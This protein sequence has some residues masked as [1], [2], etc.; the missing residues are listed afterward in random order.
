MEGFAF[1]GFSY[2]ETLAKIGK[3][4]RVGDMV[5]NFETLKVTKAGKVINLTESDLKYLAVLISFGGKVA[6][7]GTLYRIV[8]GMDGG[9]T[10]SVDTFISRLRHH[11]GRHI[12]TVHC[13]GYRW[14]VSPVDGKPDFRFRN[15]NNPRKVESRK[16]SVI[17]NRH[18]ERKEKLEKRTQV[19]TKSLSP[20]PVK[21]STP[22]VVTTM[23]P[24]PES[25][26]RIY[27][28]QGMHVQWNGKGTTP[29]VISSYY[30]T[31][32][33]FPAFITLP[34]G[35]I[36][37]NFGDHSVTWSGIGPLPYVVLHHL[38]EF[39]TL[40]PWT[41]VDLTSKGKRAA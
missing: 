31:H 13:L 20:I 14:V 23:P 22:M 21:R 2:D 25:S 6:S 32:G 34:V 24:L 17:R 10:R 35:H 36:R 33:E 28:I 26:E 41:R 7:R 8:V 15:L 19:V 38:D 18:V 39:T 16:A 4:H 37:F 11:F 5:I 1:K 9:T 12:E 30:R 29:E 40:P 3:I 27:R